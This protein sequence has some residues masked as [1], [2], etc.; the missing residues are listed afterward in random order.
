M[1]E[2][3]ERVGVGAAE[4]VQQAQAALGVRVGDLAA[5]RMPGQTTHGEAFL[6][7]LSAAKHRR[8]QPQ[9]TSTPSP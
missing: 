8:I 7:L 6:M 9:G 1:S 4:S 2:Y 5:R 3:L